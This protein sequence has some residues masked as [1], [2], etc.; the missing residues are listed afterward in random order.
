MYH[1]HH[2]T[3]IEQVLDPFKRAF[4]LQSVTRQD[5][6]RYLRDAAYKYHDAAMSYFMSA[7]EDEA[8]VFIFGSY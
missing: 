3:L 8:E 7:L 4:G 2:L 6:F 1:Y 5:F